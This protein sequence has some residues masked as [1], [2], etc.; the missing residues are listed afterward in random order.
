MSSPAQ[1]EASDRHLN[2]RIAALFVILVGST[3]S[4]VLP[5]FLTRRRSH[6]QGSRRAGLLQAL[7][8]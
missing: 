3:A 2:L 4:A 6:D 1:S 8:E 5:I 7:L